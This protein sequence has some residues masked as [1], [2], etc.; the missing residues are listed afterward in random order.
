[1]PHLTQPE[2][3]SANRTDLADFLLSRSVPL[4]KISNQYLWREENVWIHE[5]EWYSHYEQTGGYAVSFVM[6]YFNKTF[7]EAVAEL[8]GDRFSV[9][10]T[11]SKTEPKLPSPLIAPP[12]NSSTYGMHIWMYNKPED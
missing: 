8:N 1:M 4:E 11:L 10:E 5:N 12:R 2:I 6:K 3:D 9:I 7:Q